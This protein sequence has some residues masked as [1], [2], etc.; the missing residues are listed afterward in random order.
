[1]KRRERIMPNIV[2]VSYAQ[3][4]QSTKTNSMGMREMQERAYL[5]RD[6]QYL[7]LK[8][9]PASGK[10]RALM[11]IALDKLHRQGLKK[12]IVAVP[13]KAIGA[14]FS[15]TDL[16]SQGFF[17]NWETNPE[18]NLC[19]PGGEGSKVQ[20]FLRFLN[21]NEQIL[22]CTHATLRFAFEACGTELFDDTILAI[23]EFHHVSADGD[24][25]LGELLRAIMEKSNAH[26]IAMTGSYFRGDTTPILLPEDECKFAKVT[27][28]Y[29]EQLN[30]YTYLKSLGIGYHF[31]QGR[32]TSAIDEIL[33]T[34][35]KT[36]LHIPN[37][38]SGE[39]TKDKHNEVDTILD[40][41]GTVI[42]QDQETGVI[43][44]ARHNDGK[45]LKIADLV[46]DRPRERNRIATYLRQIKSPDDL[47][48]IIALGMAKEGFDWPF[49]EHSL[50]VGYRGSLTEIIQ[51]I[52][53]C[54]RDSINKTHAQFTNL[55]AQPDAADDQVKLSVNNMLKAIT[56]SLLME[57]VLAP[58]FKFKTKQ[59]EE[60]QA[61]DGEI[62]IRGFKEPSSKRVKD[63]IESDLNDLKA[64]IL[65]N[66]TMIKALP[67]NLDPEVINKVLIPKIIKI[68]Y[69]EL[70]DHEIEEVRQ[71]IVVDSVVKNGEIVVTGDKR[72]IRMAGQFVNIDDLHID[73]IDR[74]NP[75]QKA[76]EILSKSVTS[77]VLKAIQETIEAN[78]IQM[79]EEEAFLLWPKI[80]LFVKTNNGREPNLNSPD[81]LERRMGEALAY[82][83][84]QRR[85]QRL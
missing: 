9:P 3:T 57:Q 84:H 40:K 17:A 45:R 5:A 16:I 82:L 21:N 36:I 72:F 42:H 61:Q 85:S 73:L 67:G 18:Y 63:I 26:I 6:V 1:M 19:I 22:I 52:G 48:I 43:H 27:Y 49:C 75:F 69:P 4:G 83:R 54:T 8:A 10:S 28:N 47:D 29:Y 58:N 62:K 31:Y 78:R 37:V 12:V 53:R 14:S 71:H 24:S 11:Y 65:Q 46:D 7:L 13:E 64:N 68:K 60:D 41:I 81:A 34:D 39:S 77:H 56:C 35:K 38:Q 25:R 79:T 66:D 70:T 51:I 44:V 80:N 74:I 50:T 76:F 15:N 23:D 20:A 30:G 2:D 59:S 33:D 32:Y 55:I